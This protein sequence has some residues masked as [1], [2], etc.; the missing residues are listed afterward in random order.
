MSTS[1]Q[2]ST[3]NL[4][5]RAHDTEFLRSLE[6]LVH[7]ALK[8][9]KELAQSDFRLIVEF[10]SEDL[11]GRRF[12]VDDEL[13]R[14]YDGLG[15]DGRHLEGLAVVILTEERNECIEVVRLFKL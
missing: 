2:L 3:Y 5:N 9:W 7:L 12:D 15:M 1:S 6:G 10:E 14:S 4:G 8:R 13:L 11:I